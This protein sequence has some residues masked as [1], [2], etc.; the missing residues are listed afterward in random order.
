MGKWDVEMKKQIF[1]HWHSGNNVKIATP[2]EFEYQIPSLTWN[3]ELCY[4]SKRFL[5][6]PISSFEMTCSQLKV[7]DDMM[8]LVVVQCN[9]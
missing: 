5:A 9:Q 2:A 4:F 1:F 7:C 8:Q 6:T 3:S